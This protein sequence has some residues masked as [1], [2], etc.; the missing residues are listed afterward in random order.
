MTLTTPISEPLVA[1]PLVDTHCHLNFNVFNNDREEI[2]LAAR[3]QG[4]AWILNPGVDIAS[5]QA[6]VDMAGTLEGVFAAV[7]VHPNDATSWNEDS[8]QMLVHLAS[9]PK[10]VA[11]GEIGLDY[12]RERTPKDIQLNV[13]QM[14]LELAQDLGLPV[15]I[16][17]RHSISDA[18]DILADWVTRLKV[19]N[20]PLAARPGVLHSFSG[21]AQDAQRAMDLGFYIGITGPVTFKNAPELQRLVT[22]LPIERILIETDAPFLTPHPHRGQRNQPEWVRHIAE[23]IAELQH[24]SL[25]ETAKITTANARRLFFGEIAVE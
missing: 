16:H 3:N 21:N 8:L 13:F 1:I 5:S 10:V 17:T 24:R 25:E 9:Q 6:I 18:L 23:K 20:Q 11:I 15:V 4:V 22:D 7:G 19:Y 2:L 12:Y 14:Q